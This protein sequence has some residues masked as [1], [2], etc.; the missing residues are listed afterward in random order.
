M[1]LCAVE[2]IA[3]FF[4]LVGADV[5]PPTVDIASPPNGATVNG[6]VRIIAQAGDD[7]AVAAVE[8]HVDGAMR[9]RL[10]APPYAFD[11]STAAE[12]AGAH[13]LKAVA[14]DAAGNRA[15]DDDTTVTVQHGTDTTPPVTT[16]SPPGGSYGQPIAVVLSVNE[17]A[18]TYFTLDGSTPT[19]ASTRYAGPIALSSNA[20]LRFFSVDAAGNAEPVRTEQYVFTSRVHTFTSIGAEDGFVG[21][22]PAHGSSRDV[23][24]VG[25]WGMYGV[26]TYRVILSFDTSALPDQGPL[27]GATLR[28]WR[29]SGSGSVGSIWVDV[30]RGHFGPSPALE[31]QDHSAAATASNVTSV[32]PPPS[33][34]AFVDVELPASVLTAIDRS[35]RTQIRLGARTPI[36]FGAD[37]LEIEG[38]EAVGRAPTLTVRVP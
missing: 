17:P 32:S 23:H 9:A 27:I 4:G 18:S 35:G 21:A 26:D 25:D 31:T 20:T 33:D 34:G 16:A 19:T 22:L 11:W 13:R 36:D 28:F 2:E 24:R 5:T 12:P 7:I 38:G 30:Q 8:I 3:R 29:R 6:M 37:L 10:N 15:V 14:F 1:G